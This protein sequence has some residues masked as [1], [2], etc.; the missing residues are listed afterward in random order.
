[1]ER[2]LV[3][4]V[5]VTVTAS[6][7]IINRFEDYEPSRDGGAGGVGTGSPGVA[8][9]DSVTGGQPG[10]GGSN[11]ADPSDAGEG[12]STNNSCGPGT[13]FCGGLCVPIDGSNCAECGDVCPEGRICF[14]EQCTCEGPWCV[15][16]RGVAGPLC[17]V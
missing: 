13:R 4:A 5:A 16:Q 1:M 9:T 15:A 3:C 12:N 11:E 7:S 17:P 10:T 2:L 8:G 6:C 14:E